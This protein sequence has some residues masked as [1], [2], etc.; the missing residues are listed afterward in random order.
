MKSEQFA[1]N[2]VSTSG[3]LEEKLAAYRAAGFFNVEFALGQVHEWMKQGHTVSDLKTLLHAHG[4]QCIGGFETGLQAFGDEESRRCNHAHLLQNA[5][6]LS[7]LGGTILVIGTDGPGDGS[8]LEPME[9]LAQAL[10]Q[11]AAPVEPLGVTLCIEFNW[12]PFV[13]S[14]RMAAEIARLSGAANVGVLF[15]PAHYH[16]TPTKFEELN[17]HNVPWIKHVH[18]DDMHDKPGE[19]SNCNSDRALPGAGCLNLPELF[20]AIERHGYT[21][22]FSIEMFSDELWQLPPHEAAARMYQSLLPLCS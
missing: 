3:T 9:A 13:K 11:V 10:A 4:L 14:L 15:D 6:L 19:L 20:A 7:E 17:A 5:R 1:I 18:V 12:S 8:T 21:G 2:S 22:Y 16:C